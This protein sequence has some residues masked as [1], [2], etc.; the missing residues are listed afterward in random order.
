MIAS[1][2]GR[3]GDRAGPRTSGAIVLAGGRSRRFGADKL[4]A[5]LSDGRTILDHALDAATDVATE[6]V[7]VLAPGAAPPEGLLAATRIVFDPEP[8][9]GPLVGLLA[10]LEASSA[11]IVL[12]LG[13][14]MPAVE[15][16]VLR[17]LAAALDH[18]DRAD[19]AALEAGARAGRDT[20]VPDGQTHV[21]PLPC[22]LRRV[23]AI[24]ATRA[25]LAAGDRRLRACLE[26][27][28]S[29]TVA[30]VDWRRLDPDGRT[31]FDVDDPSDL[32]RLLASGRRRRGS[33]GDQRYGDAIG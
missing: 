30:A 5:R 16:A 26:R 2:D 22:A 10:G 18:D 24:G 4:A 1:A 25:A 14:D 13:G 28:A 20:D 8:F 11:G 6:I 27:L 32:E 31:L 7:L 9:G 17:L 12:V 19:A 3:V 33:R 21:A 23:P 29:T 15:P